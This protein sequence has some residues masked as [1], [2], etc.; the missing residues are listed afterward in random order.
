M[1]R[2]TTRC[3]RRDGIRRRPSARPARRSRAGR[4]VVPARRHAARSDSRHRR[5]AGRSICSIRPRVDRRDRGSARRRGSI[6]W[7][8]RRRSTRRG[9]TSSPHLRTNALGTHYLL[10]AVR[11]RS[12]AVPR[13]RRLVRAGLPGRDE[14]IDERR[15][16]RA[17]RARTGSRSSR[18][19]NSRCAPRREDGLD[20]VVARPFN[21][22]G[23]RQSAA[24][25]VSS[26]ARQIARIEAGLR[27]AG[28]SVG[29]LDTRRDMTDV[30]DVVDAYAAYDGRGAARAGRTTSA[31]AARGRSA[32]CST[33]CCHFAR[34]QVA[35]S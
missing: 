13:A 15:A 21:H 25:A 10:E 14:P 8:A 18:R 31:R 16:A 34:V 9:Q 35:S 7:P 33:S 11:T 28:D 6:T 2:G 12:A 32:T 23:P 1:T 22:A 29:N 19:T 26:F 17:G 30:R 24:F 5:L 4:R 27:A 20:V 3:H